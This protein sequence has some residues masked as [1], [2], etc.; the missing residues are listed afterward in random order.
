[1]SVHGDHCSGAAKRRRDRRLRMHWRLEQLPLERVLAAALHHSR[2]VGPVSHNA[3]HETKVE[4]HSN[5]PPTHTHTSGSSSALKKSPAGRG[6]TGCLPCP[7]GAPC[8][9][10]SIL[11]LRCRLSTMLRRRWWNS[12]LTSS[13]SFVRSHLIP[14]RFS[15]CPRFCLM[16]SPCALLCANRSW[17]NSWEKCHRSCLSLRI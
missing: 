16:T 5:D 9:R 10:S 15:K 4:Q 1:M 17:R 14:S 7:D 3:P 2:D 12:C 6:W 13:N 11:S 8:S